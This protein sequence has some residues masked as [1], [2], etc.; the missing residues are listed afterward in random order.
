MSEIA[1]SL[2]PKCS[3]AAEGEQIFCQKCGA[4][5][6]PI[7]PLVPSSKKETDSV[8]NKAFSAKAILLIF[9]LCALIDFLMSYVDHRSV[10]VGVISAVGGLFGTAF[11][12][13]LFGALQSRSDRS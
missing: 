12:L 4:T 10:P 9:L 7:Y 2:C 13:F 11:Y 6:K 8:R 3:A 1:G 5:L